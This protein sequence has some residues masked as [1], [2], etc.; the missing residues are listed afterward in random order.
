[1]AIYSCNISNVS[2]AKGSNSCATLSYISGKTVRCERTGETFRYGRNERVVHNETLLPANAP[3]EFADASVLFNAI[4]NYE[5][6]TNART[7]KK[8]IVAIPREFNLEQQKEVLREFCGNLTNEG[9]ACTFAIHHDE[10]NNN[11]HAHVLVANRQLN[12]KGKFA[13]KSKKQY[14]LDEN[15]ERIPIIDKETGQQKVDSRNRKQWKRENVQVNPLDTKAMLQQLRTSW[16]D[17][18]NERLA[19]E[20][21]ISEKSLKA[22]GKRRLPTRHEGY[23]ARAIEK[24]GGVSEICEQNR[25]IRA[26]NEHFE[27]ALTLKQK[28]QAIKKFT[29]EY[30]MKR[31]F[32]WF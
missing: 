30:Q 21:Q 14:A 8:I 31:H 16:A 27:G 15:G 26:W 20:Q 10:E 11:P 12:S 2:R 17:I 22:Q 3:R 24:R 32:R 1:M 7:A 25:E 23:A 4:E 28:E 13:I 9:Y 29:L 19:P 5:K 6:A 18:C